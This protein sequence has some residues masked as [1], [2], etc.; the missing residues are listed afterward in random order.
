MQKS[1]THPNRY[2]L[3]QYDS[4]PSQGYLQLIQTVDGVCSGF[5]DFEMSYDFLQT[6]RQRH[7]S[8]KKT[9]VIMASRQGK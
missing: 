6:L 8:I 3:S 2:M 5:D 4:A 1:L 7:K 9:S